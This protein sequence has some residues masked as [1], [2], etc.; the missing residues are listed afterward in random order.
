MLLFEVIA[1]TVIAMN[2]MTFSIIVIVIALNLKYSLSLQT[3][4]SVHMHN[5]TYS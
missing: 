4:Y 1:V 5:D 2:V 3:P